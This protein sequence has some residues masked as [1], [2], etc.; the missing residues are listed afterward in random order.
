MDFAQ[1]GSYCL[2]FLIGVATGA[3]GQ[4]FADKYTDRR[5]ESEST[6][7]SLKSFRRMKTN[8]PDLIA[9]MKKDFSTDGFSLVREFFVLEG[10]GILNT[11][12]KTI[13]YQGNEIPD[14]TEKIKMLEHEG[15]I[16]DVTPG[17]APKYRMTEEFHSL[18]MK[19]A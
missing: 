13:S 5:R 17:N 16:E 12:G 19:N 3:A 1:I 8:M 14:L 6:S 15:F 7:E 4:Y 18:L 9:A 2:V 10:G 11:K